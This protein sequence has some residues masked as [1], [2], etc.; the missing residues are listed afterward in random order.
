[1]EDTDMKEK[2][3]ALALAGAMGLTLAACSGSTRRAVIYT[4]KY[5]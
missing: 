2:L 4:F 5:S 3:L 1:M